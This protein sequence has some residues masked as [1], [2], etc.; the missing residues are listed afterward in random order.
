MH[1]DPVQWT[2]N[3]LHSMVCVTF[4]PLY[5]YYKRGMSS[6]ERAA[7]KRCSERLTFNKSQ[8]VQTLPLPPPE[9]LPAR[10]DIALE[11]FQVSTFKLT[12]N[13]PNF[14]VHKSRELYLGCAS[15]FMKASA[16]LASQLCQL[17]QYWGQFPCPS[18]VGIWQPLSGTG[19][20]TKI[21][22]INHPSDRGIRSL[23]SFG[24]PDLHTTERLLKR[25]VW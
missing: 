22:L 11:A 10:Q 9:D 19:A 16:L 15:L 1:S 3:Q 8:Q 13:I 14:C 24:I 5:D 18:L 21:R 4:S 20:F 25:E 7:G 17:M 2:Q 12:K 23:W 6:S